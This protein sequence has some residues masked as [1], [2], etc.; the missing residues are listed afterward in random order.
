MAIGIHIL[1]DILKKIDA[2]NNVFLVFRQHSML[3]TP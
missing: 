2:L 1:A 3:K